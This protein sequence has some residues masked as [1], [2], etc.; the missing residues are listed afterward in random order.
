MADDPDEVAGASVPAS[1]EKAKTATEP[2]PE[3]EAG[4]EATAETEQEPSGEEEGTEDDK[5][6]PKRPSGSER[7]R[8]QLEAARAENEDLRR[9]LPP[10]AEGAQALRQAAEQL[11]GPKPKE[12][13]FTGDYL[14][15]DRQLTVWEMRIANAED[16]IKR[17]VQTSQARQQAEN[18]AL[19]DDFHEAQ[20]QARKSIPDYDAVLRKADQDGAKAAPHVE[21][22]I[23]E[24]D[25]SAVLTYHLAK[26][27][28]RLERL[29]SLSPLQAAREIGALESRLSLPSPR[30]AT[31][32][33]AP[34]SQIKGSAGRP[35]TNADLE[36][37]SMEAYAARRLAEMKA[38]A[39]SR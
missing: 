35:A 2:A 19:V 21:R 26:N 38:K 7:Y 22:L 30:K 28:E 6:K 37:M 4:E 11:V 20:R 14:A 8:R 15:Y 3:L 23:L 9:R 25:K 39:Q 5:P 10:V 1:D 24:S 12:S 27:L 13:D 31:Q 29:N 32:A 34:P 33:T 16:G 17:E 36:S 18:R